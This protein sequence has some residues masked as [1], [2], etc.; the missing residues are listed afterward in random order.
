MQTGN[1]VDVEINKQVRSSIHDCMLLQQIWY[2]VCMKTNIS[3]QKDWLSSENGL[4]MVLVGIVFLLLYE[5][6]AV[7][8]K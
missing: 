6:N 1:L 5:T 8:G 2:L 4:K 3:H 7:K